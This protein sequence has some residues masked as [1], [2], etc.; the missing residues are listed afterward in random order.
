LITSSKRLV[1]AASKLS[2]LALAD[3]QNCSQQQQPAA[4]SSSSSDKF[5]A[6]NLCALHWVKVN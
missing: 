3:W 5:S 1:L 2:V 6:L 4:S